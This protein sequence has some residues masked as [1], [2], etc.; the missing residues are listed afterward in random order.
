MPARTAA[1]TDEV[2]P[3]VIYVGGLKEAS[4]DEIRN[5][6]KQFGEILDVRCLLYTRQIRR[7]CPLGCAFLTFKNKEAAAEALSLDGTMLCEK[8]IKVQRK[9]PKRTEKV[10]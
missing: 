3:R 8:P 6:F 2:D 9:L 5:H 7:N 4:V 10:D 1:G